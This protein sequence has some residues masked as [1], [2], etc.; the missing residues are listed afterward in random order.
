[1]IFRAGLIAVQGQV[2][3]K[4][5]CLTFYALSLQPLRSSLF[6][7]SIANSV[8]A[9]ALLSLPDCSDRPGPLE[10]GH[11]K[12]RGLILTPAEC[13]GKRGR[14]A[15]PESP[16]ILLCPCHN[17]KALSS[18]TLSMAHSYV[19][20]IVSILEG[21]FKLGLTREAEA[22]GGNGAELTCLHMGRPINSWMAHC[23][24]AGARCLQARQL[25]GWRLQS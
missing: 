10:A 19:V 3:C 6:L 11:R 20:P 7:H 15:L 12:A 1:M 8:D 21:R 16:L 14:Y 4:V 5:E 23:A 13:K 17:R 24:D 22:S 18:S 2:I 9:S 25:P